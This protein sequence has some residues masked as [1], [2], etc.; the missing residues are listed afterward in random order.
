[1]G[2]LASIYKLVQSY[3]WFL[4]LVKQP[5][6][7]SLYI[8]QCMSSSHRPK[9]NWIVWTCSPRLLPHSSFYIYTCHYRW[10]IAAIVNHHHH[11]PKL[12][13]DLY[14]AFMMRANGGNL[15]LLTKSK[16]TSFHLFLNPM[17]RRHVAVQPNE[18]YGNNI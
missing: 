4:H 7:V 8:E 3:I 12:S 18:W 13:C 6:A 14:F 11:K 17:R 5:L 1:M 16:F 15:L 9:G 2:P 10:I